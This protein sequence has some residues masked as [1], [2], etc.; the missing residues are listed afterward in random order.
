VEDRFKALSTLQTLQRVEWRHTMESERF[1][2][3][4]KE[5]ERRYQEWVAPINR[6]INEKLFLV[7]RGGYTSADFERDVKQVR[8]HQLDKYDPYQEMYTLFDRMCPHY[9]AAASRERKAIRSVVS[10]KDGILSALLG[11]A[12]RAATQLRTKADEEWLDKG[13]AAVSIENCSKDY[14]DVLLALA[15]L[16]VAAEEMGINPKPAFKAAAALSSRE[17]PRGGKTPVSKMLSSF[18]SYGALKERRGRKT[19]QSG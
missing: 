9:L 11:Y 16:Y 5:L 10:D 7:S 2:E 17:T 12:Y 4:L 15:E 14:R 8:E 6:I 1:G 3:R 18:H 13:L 19:S